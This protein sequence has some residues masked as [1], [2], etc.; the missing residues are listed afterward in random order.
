MNQTQQ[1]NVP[2]RRDRRRERNRRNLL[3]TGRALIAQRGVAGL[4]IQEITERA[5]IA[6]GSFYNYFASKEELVEAVVSESLQEF[7]SAT[8]PADEANID[9]AITVAHAIT[10]FMRLSDSDPDFARLI[11]NLSHADVLFTT[12]V[13]P[14]ARIALERGIDQGRFVIADIEVTLTAVTGAALALIR[15]ILEG[16]KTPDIDRAFSLHVLCSLGL[17]PSEASEVW[18]KAGRI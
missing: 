4:R 9:P 15:E 7:A 16:H 12:A 14:Y 17:S 11:V 13:Y 8:I 3:D 1:T 5:D 18:N 2:T 10:R 6:L